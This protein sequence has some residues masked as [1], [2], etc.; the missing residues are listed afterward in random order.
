MDPIRDEKGNKKTV[1]MFSKSEWG[2]KEDWASILTE[3]N[4]RAGIFSADNNND[5]DSIDPQTLVELW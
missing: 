4:T 3:A 2:E 5:D 1:P